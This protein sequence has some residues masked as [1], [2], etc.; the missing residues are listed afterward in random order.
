VTVRAGVAT[1]PS[2]EIRDSKDLVECADKALYK[3][4]EKGRNRVET[5]G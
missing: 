1:F 2:E 5:W 3:A 4:K